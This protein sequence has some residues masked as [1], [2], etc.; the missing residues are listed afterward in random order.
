[1]FACVNRQQRRLVTEGRYL[2]RAVASKSTSSDPISTR[3][4][5]LGQ[6][7]PLSSTT[8]KMSNK[9][10]TIDTLNP[11]VKEVEYAVRGPIVQLAAEIEKELD[12]VGSLDAVY[13]ANQG[14]EV[15][16][17]ES[18]PDPRKEEIVAG[19][20][21]NLALSRRGRES[22]KKAGIEA[23]VVENGIPMYARMIHSHS[24]EQTPIP[25]G[26][27]HQHILSV[28]RRKLNELLIDVSEKNPKVHYH[29]KHKIIGAD[30]DAATLKIADSNGEEKSQTGDLV[31]G[32]DGAFSALRKQLMRKM[33]MDFNQTY[34]PHGYKEIQMLPKKNGDFMMEPNYLH[35]W[36]RNTF[37]MIALPNQDQTF[38]C[39]LFM[40]Y[41]IFEGIQTETDIIAFF[42]REFP[43]AIPLIGR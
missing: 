23:Q 25:Y 32:C 39:T 5:E 9:L 4:Q 35:I 31:V 24:G 2:H 15:H 21:I 13:F 42:E 7:R 33:R 10:L 28:D 38:T 14:Y 41:A 22:L 30:L 40:P 27:K 20:S 43:D 1:M 26:K 29:F 8:A 17:Y 3:R 11:L 37:M 19:R 6:L 16:V 34:I 36:P 18:R 12:S